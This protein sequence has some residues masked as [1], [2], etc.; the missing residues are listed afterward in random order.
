[1]AIEILQLED[2]EEKGI[3]YFEATFKRLAANGVKLATVKVPVVLFPQ[4]PLRLPL[5]TIKMEFGSSVKTAANDYNI[6]VCVF[7]V[8]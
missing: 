6:R 2:G 4:Y 1:M 7:C 5:I 3:K 8:F